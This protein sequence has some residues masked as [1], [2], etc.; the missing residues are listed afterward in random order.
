MVTVAPRH[1]VLSNGEVVKVDFQVSKKVN[2]L[3]NKVSGKGK[4]GA[5]NLSPSSPLCDV[6]CSNGEKYTLYRCASIII[7]PFIST[8]TL[9]DVLVENILKRFPLMS[10]IV[11]H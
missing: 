2:R 8:I 4:K 11:W 5:Q 9:T 7:K 3:D 6:T 10:K 1:P